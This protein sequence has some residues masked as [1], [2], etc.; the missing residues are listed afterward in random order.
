MFNFGLI[1]FLFYNFG[2]K[3]NFIIKFNIDYQKSSSDCINT[4]ASISE[5]SLVF[6]DFT[7]IAMFLCY[8]IHKKKKT[9]DEYV[10]EYL[11]DW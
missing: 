7:E 1:F 3:Q 8:F 5:K 10:L 9:K 6:L 11:A 4:S 2:V